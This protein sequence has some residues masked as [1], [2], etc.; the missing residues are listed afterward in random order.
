M[1]AAL[2][3]RVMVLSGRVDRVA[4]RALERAYPV[5]RRAWRVAPPAL[6]AAATLLWRGLRPLLRLLFLALSFA[7]A[8]LRAGGRAAVRVTTAAAAVLTPRRAIG[9]VIVATGA[10][11]VVSQFLDYHGVQIG[12]PG[13]VGLAAVTKPPTIDLKT[14]GQAHSYV[15]VP[16]GA[17][18]VLLGLAMVRRG[19]R[20]GRRAA[21]GAIVA[22]AG[23]LAVI[24]LVDLPSGLDVGAQSSRFAGAAAVL[25]KGFAAELAAAGGMVLGGVLYYARPCLIRISSSGRAASARRRRPRRRASSRAKVARSA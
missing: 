19:G 8:A 17:I 3:A 24:L 1:I 6:L 15:L 22:G 4:N 13:Y 14:A 2:R 9:L 12:G 20:A 23:S 7:E 5:L 16:V 10:L 11:L 25:E 21:L 18:A